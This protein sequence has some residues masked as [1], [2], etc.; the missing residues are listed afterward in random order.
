MRVGGGGR[1]G[2]GGRGGGGVGGWGGV[3]GGVRQ[4]IKTDIGTMGATLHEFR[5]IYISIITF[6][7]VIH[8]NIFFYYN[9]ILKGA[10]IGN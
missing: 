3:G 6:F 10:T 4:G 8:V 7:K 1:G 2:E 5:P 9:R